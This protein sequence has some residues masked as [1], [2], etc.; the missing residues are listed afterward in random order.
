MLRQHLVSEV[1]TVLNDDKKGIGIVELLPDLLQAA[2]Y[3]RAGRNAPINRKRKG[4]CPSGFLCYGSILP[5]STRRPQDHPEYV[6]GHPGHFKDIHTSTGCPEVIIFGISSE[7]PWD[8]FR[9]SLWTASEEILAVV[10]ELEKET[11]KPI[12]DQAAPREF[13][14]RPTLEQ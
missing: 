4:T 10:F 2:K 5:N 12:C 3:G 6:P 1:N 14:G 11:F 8:S 13:V 9:T 7:H